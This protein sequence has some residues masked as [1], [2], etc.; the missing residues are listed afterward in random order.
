MALRSALPLVAVVLALA[1]P[2]RAIDPISFGGIGTV[3]SEGDGCPASV[4][5]PVLG[6][7][8]DDGKAIVVALPSFSVSTSANTRAASASCNVQV[9]A[10]PVPNV[11]IA[12]ESVEYFPDYAIAPN[13]AG[14][15]NTWKVRAA[16]KVQTLPDYAFPGGTHG[17]A[18]FVQDFLRNDDGSL[19]F[20][21]CGKE[22]VAVTYM[23]LLLK[24]QS[25]PF[26]APSHLALQNGPGTR[27]VVFHL[28]LEPCE[29][30]ARAISSETS[31]PPF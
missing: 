15:L 18:P 14:S 21:E 7:I 31:A 30:S 29:G 28:K 13:D 3:R 1:G 9:V 5:T 11:R 17:D 4:A 23:R 12:L 22:L 10:L 20:A 27:S 25:E 8:S 2:A 24:R 16:G 19:V 6:N 26:Q